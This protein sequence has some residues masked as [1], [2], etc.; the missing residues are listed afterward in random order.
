MSFA[1]QP[2]RFQ[3]DGAV[4]AVLDPGRPVLAMQLAAQIPRFL[5]DGAV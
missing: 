4:L 2:P 5:L 1:V 3:L